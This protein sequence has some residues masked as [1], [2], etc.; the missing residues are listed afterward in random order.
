MSKKYAYPEVLV[1]TKWL[2]ENLSKP[3][4]RVVEVDWKGQYRRG[5]IPGG[6]LFKWQEDLWDPL[7]RDFVS[8][9]SFEDLMERFGIANE[10]VVIFYGESEQFATYAFWLLKY[11]GHKDTCILNGGLEKW[12]LEKRRLT[13][14]VPNITPTK[15]MSKEPD[16][17]IRVLKDYVLES[18]G[19]SDQLLLDVRSPEEYEGKRVSPPGMSD[20]GAYRAG[21]IPGAVHIYWE[22]TLHP[23]RTFKS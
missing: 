1:E 6:V 19:R 8:R 9:E 18:I 14:A 5:H 16:E 17:S 20:Y 4:I 15:Y 10:T 7:K 21:C 11:Y 22:D 3:S 13:R 12:K 23:D 2:A